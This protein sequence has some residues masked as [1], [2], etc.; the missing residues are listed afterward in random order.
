MEETMLPVPSL[1]RVRLGQF[2]TQQELAQRAGLTRLSIG[3]IEGGQPARV[4]TIKKLA[5]ALEVE[6]AALTAPVPQEQASGQH[7][8]TA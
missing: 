2:L 6:P 8:A 5:S 4:S 1:K 7:A 3:R